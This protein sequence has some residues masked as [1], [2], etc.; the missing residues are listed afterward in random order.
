MIPPFNFRA[1]HETPAGMELMVI[2]DHVRMGSDHSVG[3][4]WRCRWASKSGQV[5]VDTPLGKMR[6]GQLVTQG[7]IVVDQKT[8]DQLRRFSSVH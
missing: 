3:M 1:L 4:E 2:S 6:R 7:N 8:A 5:T